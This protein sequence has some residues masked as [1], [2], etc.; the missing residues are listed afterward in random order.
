MSAIA[1]WFAAKSIGFGSVAFVCLCIVAIFL[2]TSRQQQVDS[3]GSRLSAYSVFNR[4][5]TP[6]AGSLRA[7]D[8][9]RELR[10]QERDEFESTNK[11]TTNLPAY[12]GHPTRKSAAANAKCVCGSGSVNRNCVLQS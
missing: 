8:F 12:K 5:A 11:L 9:E 4:N 7:A 10:H 6:I 3:V 1:I 2:S